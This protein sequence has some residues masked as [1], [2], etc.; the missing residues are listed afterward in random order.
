MQ[1]TCDR[2]GGFEK[3]ERK[4]RRL[5]WPGFETLRPRL[6]RQCCCCVKCGHGSH[7]N[8]PEGP[9]AHT[10]TYDTFI[11]SKG[12]KVGRPGKE[13]QCFL[14]MWQK[15]LIID[16]GNRPLSHVAQKNQFQTQITVLNEKV[17]TLKLLEGNGKIWPE[18]CLI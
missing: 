7:W 1:M 10:E 3:D 2:Q 18:R 15:E 13:R 14:E 16:G 9:E 6:S 5:P 12:A 17:E 4:V 11:C 8:K